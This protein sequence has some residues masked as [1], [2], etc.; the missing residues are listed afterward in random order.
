MDHKVFWY[1]WLTSCY[2][3]LVR[4]NYVNKTCFIHAWYN[5]QENVSIQAKEHFLVCIVMWSGNMHH[6]N[7]LVFLL[8][9]SV[10]ILFYS[11]D[12]KCLKCSKLMFKLWLCYIS[13]L[14]SC[15][16][17]PKRVYQMYKN[18]YQMVKKT[19]EMDDLKWHIR[20]SER[21]IP[22]GKKGISDGWSK[23]YIRCSKIHTRWLKR[24][25]RWSKGIPVS[26]KGIPDGHVIIWYAYVNP[27]MHTICY[28]V[29]YAT[30]HG[31]KLLIYFS[32]LLYIATS[33][34]I[35]I[36]VGSHIYIQVFI[37]W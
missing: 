25:T 5:L 9:H 19:Y 1:F 10:I 11:K 14:P 16:Y 32:I 7:I 37:V 28:R 35:K 27:I 30:N 20:W 24:L 3:C 22:F 26:Q 31:I 18:T 2:W 8:C 13:I 21:H 17:F 36:I 6:S 15:M 12:I 29:C 4:F 34:H 33:N 23:R